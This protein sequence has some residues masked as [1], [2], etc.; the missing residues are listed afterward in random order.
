[1]RCTPTT[2]R[3]PKTNEGNG[4]LLV[5]QKHTEHLALVPMWHRPDPFHAGGR[6]QVVNMPMK[7]A[8]TRP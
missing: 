3:A 5:V 2:V 4:Y 7:T 6:V 8:P 1:M